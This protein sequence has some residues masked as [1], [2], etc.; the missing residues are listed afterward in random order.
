MVKIHTVPEWA[1]SLY[2]VAVEVSFER[3]TTDL[4]NDAAEGTGRG[5]FRNPPK[6]DTGSKLGVGEEG[7][8]KA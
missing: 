6:R 4:R 5:M 8:V 1:S 7:G 3:G 2:P